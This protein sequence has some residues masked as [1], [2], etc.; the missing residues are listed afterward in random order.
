MSKTKKPK[1]QA[2]IPKFEPNQWLATGTT[3]IC[4][5][6]YGNLWHLDAFTGEVRP[7]R[8]ARNKKQKRGS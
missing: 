5:D 8:M 7:V 4:S 1:A 6:S 3:A 2:S